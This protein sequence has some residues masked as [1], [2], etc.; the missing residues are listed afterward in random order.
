MYN[1]SENPTTLL[2][3]GQVYTSPLACVLVCRLYNVDIVYL[4]IHLKVILQ[5]WLQKVTN[6]QVDAKISSINLYLCA[7]LMFVAGQNFKDDVSDE[8]L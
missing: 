2:T 5:N 1:I 3:V 6:K 7:D 8:I 4:F